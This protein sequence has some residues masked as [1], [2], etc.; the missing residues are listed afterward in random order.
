MEDN[1]I[2]CTVEMDGEVSSSG[3]FVAILARDDGDASIYYNTDAITLG[4]SMKMIARAFVRS[5]NEL[6]EDEQNMVRRVLGPMFDV[7]K[8]DQ[9]DE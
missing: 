3:D 4:M 8:E 9:T 1:K 6:T 7:R 5:M 2:L